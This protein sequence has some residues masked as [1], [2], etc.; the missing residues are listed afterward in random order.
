M[1]PKTKK[2]LNT[3]VKV[4]ETG[5]RGVAGLLLLALRAIATVLLIAITTGVLFA[6]I[7]A[8]YVK[9]TLYKELDVD[10]NEFTL[11]QSST[12]LAYDSRTNDYT[13]LATLYSDENRV[14]VDYKDIPEYAEHA[15]VAIEDKRFYK[16]QGV[17]WYRTAGA[18]ATMFLQMKSTFGS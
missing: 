11:N 9:T 3:A 4:T 10:L 7:F 17:D 1:K 6:C 13:V 8:V 2:A 18:M 14:W 12:I 5:F 15:A 16:H